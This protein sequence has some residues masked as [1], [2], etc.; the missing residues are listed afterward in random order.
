MIRDSLRII[1]T[2]CILAGGILYFTTDNKSPINSETAQ[3]QVTVKKLQSEL[4]KTKEALGIAQTTSLVKESA[5]EITKKNV[6]ENNAPTITTTLTI[7]PGSNSTVV[8]A[9]LEKLGIIESAALFDTFL[10]DNGLTGRIQI[11]EH[12]IDSSMN[13]QTI[14]KEITTIK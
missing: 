7:E 2:A 1:G 3:L 4:S 6:T 5:V 12:N 8:S 10:N 13:F 9:T 14:A 11:G